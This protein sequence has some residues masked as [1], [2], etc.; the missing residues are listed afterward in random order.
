MWHFFNKQLSAIIKPFGDNGEGEDAGKISSCLYS[1][2]ISGEGGKKE[3]DSLGA[4]GWSQQTDETSSC[5]Q[6]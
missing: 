4:G 6:R 3:G 1:R 2:G 5:L